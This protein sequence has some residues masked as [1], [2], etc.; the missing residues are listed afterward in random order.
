MEKKSDYI[1]FHE[2]VEKFDEIE[3]WKDPAFNF[4]YVFGCLDTKTSTINDVMK[5]VYIGAI[6]TGYIHPNFS[7]IK[8][9]VYDDL[10]LHNQPYSCLVV[11]YK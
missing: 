8:P 4:E 1:P 5:D 7:L 10:C 11:S 3:E 2:F 9:E 6:D